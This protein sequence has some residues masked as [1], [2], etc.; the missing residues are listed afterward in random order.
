MTVFTPPLKYNEFLT[1]YGSF[2][3]SPADFLSVLK[4]FGFQFF[5]LEKKNPE[6][7]CVCLNFL[8]FIL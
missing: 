4:K 7:L 1:E 5:L 8:N 3:I 6:S 2:S